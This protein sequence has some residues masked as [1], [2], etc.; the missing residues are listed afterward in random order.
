MIVIGII[1]PPAGGKSTIAG[2]LAEAGATWINADRLAHGALSMG[3]VKEELRAHFGDCIFN[4]SG[5]VDRS[6]LAAK[7]FGDD[8]TSGRQLEYIEGV[9]HP[10]V[11]RLAFRK[12]QRLETQTNAAAVL[13][14][15]LLIEAKWHLQCDEVWYVDSPWELRTQWIAKRSW[16][17]EQ[18][19]QREMRQLPLAEKKRYATR[20]IDNARGSH[21]TKQQVRAAWQQITHP[22]D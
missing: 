17:P 21:H 22:T 11:R 2:M 4:A 7:V 14:A 19:R 18:L 13:D 10:V 9:L 20:I 3:G 1:G 6:R 16:T 8:P 12:L 15:P 5:G